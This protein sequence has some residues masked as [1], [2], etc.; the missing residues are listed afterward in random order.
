[1]MRSAVAQLV[2][3]QTWDRRVDKSTGEVLSK[4]LY[5]MLSPG[6]THEDPSQQDCKINDWDDKTSDDIVLCDIL[7]G[8]YDMH[9]NVEAECQT[10]VAA[11]GSVFASLRPTGKPDRQF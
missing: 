11:A 8:E 7:F 4:T 1:M 10:A 9:N 6:S 3:R 5:P 2:E